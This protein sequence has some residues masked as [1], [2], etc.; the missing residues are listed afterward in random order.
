M[1]CWSDLD[2]IPL[3]SAA[4]RLGIRVPQDLAVIG[5]D[6]SPVAGLSM[7]DLT[8]VDQGGP[9]LGKLA[10]EALFSRMNGRSVAEHILTEPTLIVRGSL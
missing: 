6:N 4:H 7:V 10:A 9:R 3:L 5:Y 2:A 1:I 8:S